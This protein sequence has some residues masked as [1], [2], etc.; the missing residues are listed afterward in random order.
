MAAKIEHAI[1][2]NTPRPAI[3][4]L[5]FIAL[6]VHVDLR[7]AVKGQKSNMASRILETVVLHSKR[8]D[9]IG[10]AYTTVIYF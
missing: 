9:N 2:E 6:A 3:K 4:P 10:F 8:L 7:C 5:T 1:L